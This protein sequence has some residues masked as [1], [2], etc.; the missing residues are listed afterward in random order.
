MEPEETKTECRLCEQVGGLF[1]ILLGAVILFI[2]IDVLTGGSL[3]TLISG[4]VTD[5]ES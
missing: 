1:G 3:S 5:D 4:G 2:G